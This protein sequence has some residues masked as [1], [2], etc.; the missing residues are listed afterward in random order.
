[1]VQPKKRT[2]Q[3][4]IWRIYE[5]FIRTATTLRITSH[6]YASRTIWIYDDDI[7]CGAFFSLRT[8]ETEFAP[9]TILGRMKTTRTI[10]DVLQSNIV[11][12]VFRRFAEQQKL[13]KRC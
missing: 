4:K 9:E 7:G 8:T 11:L 6:T 1:M 3:R 5:P 12:E 13:R 10:V 2:S